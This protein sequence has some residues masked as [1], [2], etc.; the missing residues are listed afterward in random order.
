MAKAYL[1]SPAALAES[2]KQ[3]RNKLNETDRDQRAELQALKTLD[4][5]NA[6][7]LAEQA[8]KF[9]ALVQ[10]LKE[11]G[12]AHWILDARGR[13]RRAGRDTDAGSGTISRQQP[14]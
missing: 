5:L 1:S 11:I 6:A 3:R 12:V 10:R 13:V 14:A 2:I 4:E 7:A 9:S 8:G